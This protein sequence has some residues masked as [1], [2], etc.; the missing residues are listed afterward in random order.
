MELSGPN[1]FFNH[2]RYGVI[3]R[4]ELGAP[5]LPEPIYSYETSPK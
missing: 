4:H 5:S 1:A 3:T 2:E